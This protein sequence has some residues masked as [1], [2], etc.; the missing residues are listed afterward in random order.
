[1]A[2]PHVLGSPI[3][4]DIPG[5]NIAS[6]IVPY[7]Q[8]DTYA[9]HTEE[10]GCGGY[11]TVKTVDE[12]NSIPKARRKIGMLVNVI[13]EGIFKLTS[14]KTDGDTTDENWSSLNTVDIKSVAPTTATGNLIT[15]SDTALMKTVVEPDLPTFIFNIFLKAKNQY[16]KIRWCLETKDVKPTITYI[17]E[18]VDGT[19]EEANLLLNDLDD[20]SI[21]EN[22]TKIFE[23]E[24]WDGGKSWFVT[25]KVFRVA[26]ATDPGKEI[27]TRDK[28]NKALSW[29]RI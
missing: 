29:Q 23:F 20:L 14:D 13:S 26:T 21:S 16:T 8:T 2:D 4:T 10:Y 27:I 7:K 12:R 3:V 28:L 9:T 11:R 6:K 5:T 24:T 25:T 19:K 15:L 1:M 22:E 17:T 18:Q